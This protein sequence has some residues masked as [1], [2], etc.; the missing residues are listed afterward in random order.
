MS[1]LSE[2]QNKVNKQKTLL[3]EL[4]D[5]AQQSTAG[6]ARRLLRRQG[7]ASRA[8]QALQSE[9]DAAVN[10]VAYLRQAGRLAQ[11]N[12]DVLGRHIETTRLVDPAKAEGMERDRVAAQREVDGIDHEIA[13]LGAP[14]TEA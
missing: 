10:R 11:E 9:L 3:N 7:Q 6:E 5:M 8:L 12:L 13:R 14:V 2:L 1:R 4:A